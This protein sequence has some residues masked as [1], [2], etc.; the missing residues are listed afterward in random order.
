MDSGL[1]PV[2]IR[3]QACPAASDGFDPTE[4]NG[5]RRASRSPTIL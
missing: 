4:A 2:M 3:V 1:A 5:F